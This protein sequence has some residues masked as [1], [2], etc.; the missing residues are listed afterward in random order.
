MKNKI[1]NYDFLIVGSG[2]IG[3]LAA[4]ALN[5]KKYKV[6]VVEKNNSPRNDNRTL[7]VNARS[8]DFIHWL[9]IWELLPSSA[10]PINEIYISDYINKKPLKFESFE[11]PMGNVIYNNDL[12]TLAQKKLI[13]LKLLKKNVDI[14][15]DQFIPRQEIIIANTKYIFNK[16][17][18]CVG[19]QATFNQIGRIDLINK[20]KSYVGFFKHQKNHLQKA[21]EIFTKDGPLAVLPAPQKTK[22]FSTFIYSTSKKISETNIKKLIQ[23]H[24]Q[25]SHGKIVFDGKISHFEVQPHIN[26]PKI[27]NIF[28]LGDTLRSIHPVAGQGWNLGVKDI[29]TL[30]ELLDTYSID[31]YSLEKIFYTR[32]FIESSIY[33]GFTSALNFLYENN[34]SKNKLIIKSGFKLLDKF[35]FLRKGFINQAMGR[36]NLI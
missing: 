23:I 9:R 34:Y 19:K 30:C 20:H 25:S 4:L 29:Q 2:L 16:I 6:L 31:D 13:Q 35:D 15:F 17:I 32:R 5:Q 3:S 21:Y 1:L 24:F 33:L 36:T 22:K 28:L 14:Q 27:K 7:A 10:E 8:R 11:E 26:K 18:F 12:L